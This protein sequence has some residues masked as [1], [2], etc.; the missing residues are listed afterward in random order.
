MNEQI[1]YAETSYDVQDDLGA[2]ASAANVEIDPG[3]GG[4][5]TEIEFNSALY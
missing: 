2:I 3:I 4:A 1:K 5:S